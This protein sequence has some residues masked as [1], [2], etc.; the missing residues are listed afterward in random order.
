MKQL[1]E[2]EGDGN[3]RRKARLRFVLKSLG[4]EK[5]IE[6]FKNELN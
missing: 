5:F 3:D 4:E 6:K 2:R 1:F